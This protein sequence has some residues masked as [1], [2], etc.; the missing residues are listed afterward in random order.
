MSDPVLLKPRGN[1]GVVDAPVCMVAI[2]LAG[3]ADVT[4]ETVSAWS[5]EQRDIA[6]DWAAR[7]YLRANGL[8]DLPLPARPDFLPVLPAGQTMPMPP[9]S[10]PQRTLAMPAIG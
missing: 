3:G 5:Q 8:P 1:G 7:T 6:Y 2:A 10:G 4:H 9:I